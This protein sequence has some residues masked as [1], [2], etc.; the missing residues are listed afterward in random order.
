[1]MKKKSDSKEKKAEQKEKQVAF[2]NQ[3]YA[4]L[5][6][7]AQ[8]CDEYKEQL[9]SA[10]AEFDNARKRME[11]ERE[12]FT[13]F[14]NSNLVK[15]LLNV[16][17]DLERSIKVAKDKHADLK[18]LISANE[19][20][21]SHLY[22]LLKK[23]GVSPINPQGEMFD[24]YMHEVLMQVE[25]DK[26]PEDTV[27]EVMQKGYKMNDKVLRTAKVATARSPQEKKEKDKED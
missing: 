12:D 21:L 11:K 24:P 15:D 20:I 19:M 26:Y 27:I 18:T 2:S 6:E 8:K 13:K 14:A 16:L 10:R 4:E 3:E 23:E 1:M 17:D 5:K 22:E 25:T 9:L 7:K